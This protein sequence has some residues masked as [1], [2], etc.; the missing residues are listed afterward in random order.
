M[1]TCSVMYNGDMAPKMSWSSFIGNL[2]GVD[3]SQP[4]NYTTVTVYAE[5]S[6]YLDKTKFRC[7]TYFDK[8]TLPVNGSDWAD[9]TPDYSFTY[10]TPALTVHCEYF[11]VFLENSLSY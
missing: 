4:G 6:R 7:V 1:S 10:E 11:S 5:A 3:E 8:P 9:N 2:E